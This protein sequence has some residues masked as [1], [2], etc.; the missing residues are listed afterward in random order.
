M[1]RFERRWALQIFD[2]I[3][4]SGADPRLPMGAR[5]FPLDRFLV[6]L[7]QHASRR[8]LLG[9][10]IAIWLVVWAPILFIRRLRR[11]PGLATD[12]RL[13]VLQKMAGS[14]VYFVRELVTLLKMV[15]CLAFCG[16]PVIQS[17]VGF[18]RVH[19]NPP[20]WSQESEEAS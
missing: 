17:Q 15:A 4:P 13:K 11:F 8:F 1:F 14:R 10:R 18:D 16:M 2:T 9:L 6:D 5:D 3:L 20:D 12:D 19:A 7:Q